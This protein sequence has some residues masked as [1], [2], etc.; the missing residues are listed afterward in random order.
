MGNFFAKI[1]DN[2]GVQDKKILML[3]LDA[4]GKTTVLYK[5]QLGDA[6]QTIPTI[7]FNVET[8]KYKNINFTTWDVGGQD[9]IR[10]LWRHYYESCDGVIFVVDSN[11]KV[12]FKEAQIEL[13]KMLQEDTMKNV[14]LLVF[15]N[16]QDLPNAVSPSELAQGL[17]L[18]QQQQEWF[19]QGCCAPSGEGLF[20]GLDWLSGVLRDR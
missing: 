2:W 12:R 1:F 9:A 6:L 7:G 18:D 13:N 14:K 16:K 8:V 11:D 17:K 20:D 3:G 19:I 15:A 4:A 10:K 5:L